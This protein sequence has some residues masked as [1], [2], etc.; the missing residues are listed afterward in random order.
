VL[1]ALTEAEVIREDG[2]AYTL[3]T[4]ALLRAWPRLRDW[5]DAERDGLDVHHALADSARFWD[6]HGRKNSDL[7][8]GSALDR[9]LVWTA[10]ERRHLA[11]NTLE[12]D[13]LDSAL[14]LTRRRGR[15][16][17]L[18]IAALSLLLV[19]ALGATAFSVVQNDTVSRQRDEALAAKV[20]NLAL[21]MRRTDPET[22]RRLAIVAGDLDRRGVDAR[23]ALVA[24]Y[25][26]WERYAYD[27]PEAHRS[28]V[29][30]SDRTGSLLAYNVDNGEQGEDLKIVDVDGRREVQTLR[31]P[32]GIGYISMAADGKS[33]SVT[34]VQGGLTRVWDVATGQPGPQRFTISSGP[35]ELSDQGRHLIWVPS[36]ED[37]NKDVRNKTFVYDT[38]N[39]GTVLKL[40]FRAEDWVFSPN[41][42]ALL[43]VRDKVRLEVWDLATGKGTRMALPLGGDKTPITN[44]AFSPN[45]RFLAFRQEADIKVIDLEAGKVIMTLQGARVEGATPQNIVF[46]SDGSYLAS[47][48]RVWRISERAPLTPLLRYESDLC[49]L[50]RFGPDDRSL[51]CVDTDH[52]A[53]E[54]DI[55]AATAPRELVPERAFVDAQISAD[56]SVLLVSSTEGVTLWDPVRGTEI[57]ELPFTGTSPYEHHYRFS[58]DGRLLLESGPDGEMSIWD[59]K[60]RQKKS[61]WKISEGFQGSFLSN[62]SSGA[63]ARFSPD[64]RTLVLWDIENDGAVL[65]F[66]ETDSGR[67]L[68]RVNSRGLLDGP[69][70]PFTRD[71]RS[72]VVGAGHG[73]VEFPSG[74]IATPPPTRF[75]EGV[76]ALSPDDELAVAVK[77]NRILFYDAGTLQHR[78]DLRAPGVGE[79]AAFSRDG[80]VLATSDD[81]G[82]IRLWDVDYRRSFGLPLTGARVESR[83]RGFV[84]AL[85]FSPDGTSVLS[86]DK[87]GHL[88]D[89]LV[90][91]ARIKKALCDRVGPLSREDWETYIPELPYR[92]TC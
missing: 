81:Q 72:V 68:R 6:E 58:D 74:R 44:L 8:Q 30:V 31:P 13:F 34:E 50:L 25:H 69:T 14:A 55:S 62:S 43:T 1:Q 83:E 86:V 23:S 54:I 53:L 11:L 12:R 66:R 16:R 19:L 28:S 45:A 18:V 91:P 79:S 10:A 15:S 46:S 61:S 22:A 75:V 41:E 9:A 7:Y 32:G 17:T 51:R 24:L 21:S 2:G 78:F 49:G 77:T 35:A 67:L 89:H 85:A 20:A 29:V 42:K 90:D 5:V 84:Q 65:Q 37:P 63:S 80:S 47:A 40:P 88:R 73:V 82:Q 56:G 60:T 26:Q 3:A 27:P 48:H 33:V 57:G 4:P 71:G 36:G 76:V 70:L 39:G 52:T 92:E 64:G 59:V 87:H 38:G